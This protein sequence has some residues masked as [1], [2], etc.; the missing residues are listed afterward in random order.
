MSAARPWWW[1]LRGPVTVALTLSV[2][3]F[4]TPA[5]AATVPHSSAALPSGRTSYRAFADYEADLSR[6]AAAHPTKARRFMLD[7]SSL[8][9]RPV[10]ALE[11]SRD[12]AIGEHKPVLLVTGAHHARE[13]PSAE[14]TMEFAFDLLRNDGADPR[15]TALLDRIRVVVVPMVN[16]D[17]FKISRES[18]FAMKRRNCRVRDG[19]VPAPGECAR[20]ANFSYGVDLNRNYGAGWSG[21]GSVTSDTYPGAAPFSEP[22]TQN[23]RD[24]VSSR[25]VTV[26]LS[27]HTYG[28]VVLRPTNPEDGGYRALADRLA[29]E[30]GYGSSALNVGGMTERW[31]YYATAGFGFTVEIGTGG[32]HPPFQTG[33]IDQYVGTGGRRGLRS[34]YLTAGEAADRKSVV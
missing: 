19:Q 25:Q 20:S 22:E 5:V 1:T 17:G 18:T 13:W 28:A 31:S 14:T 29:G 4:G 21:G 7:R 11:I 26:L 2:V 9:G 8:E 15:V 33:V 32:F 23:I 24:L 3:A 34:M 6:L 10:I 12:V 16:P 27:N 30:N